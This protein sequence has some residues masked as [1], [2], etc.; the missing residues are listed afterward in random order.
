MLI[1]ELDVSVCKNCVNRLKRSVHLLTK[2][3]SVF[4]YT[5]EKVWSTHIHNGLLDTDSLF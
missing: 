4:T 1:E 5:Q 2:A 3:A